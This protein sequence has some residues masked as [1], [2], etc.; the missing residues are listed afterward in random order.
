VLILIV[1]IIVF[2]GTHT[3][4]T[5]RDKRALLIGRLGAGPFKGV[6]SLVALAGFAMICW[7]FSRY[8]AEGL[9][10]LWTPPV[11]GRHLAIVLMW[12]A[13]V[14]LACSNPKA[15][16]RIRGWLRH[17]MLA[18]V[19]IWALAHLLANGDLGGLVL[20]GSFLAWAVYD[21]V[22]VKRRGDIGAD[23]IRAFTRADAIAVGAGT[24]AYVAM[25]FLHPLLIGVA[26]VN[27]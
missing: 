8:R 26:V 27:W 17:P 9:I 22:A 14:A 7:G 23:R 24:V 18:A 6:Y 2:L 16:G 20:F 10:P 4:T 1:G 13:F 5:F 11:W 15:P 19:K 12:F 21:R 3:F 25:I